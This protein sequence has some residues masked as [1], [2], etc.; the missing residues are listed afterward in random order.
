MAPDRVVLDSSF[1]LESILPTTIELKRQADALIADLA[2]GDLKAVAP[3][4]FF[5][6]VAVVCAKAVR[7]RRL[8]VNDAAEFLDLLP[9]L[10]LDLEFKLEP[11]LAIFQASMRTGAQAYDS[12][13]LVLAEAM[14]L[15]IA[16]IDGGM[17]TAARALNIPVYESRRTQTRQ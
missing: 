10:G 14:G 16:S 13:Y 12:M 3:W 17:K 11:P 5:P 6:E 2:S 9:Q 4:I 15:P 8:A 1:I 7:G